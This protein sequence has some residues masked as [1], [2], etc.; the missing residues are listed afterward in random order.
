MYVKFYKDIDSLRTVSLYGLNITLILLSLNFLS[1]N[2]AIIDSVFIRNSTLYILL[3]II[4]LNIPFKKIYNNI[5]RNNLEIISLSTTFLGIGLIIFS[6]ILLIVTKAPLLWLV[7]IPIFISGLDLTLQGIKIIRKE[8]YLIFL[9]SF[10]Y[11]MFYLLVQTIPFLWH[12]IQR[13][14]LVV[15]ST[16][17]L[18]IGKPMLLGPTASGL[19]IIIIFF[20]IS[21]IG[22]FLSF[23]KKLQLIN[24]G[25]HLVGVFIIWIIYLIFLGFIDF[26]SK[27]DIV[28]IHLILFIFCLF[29]TF[30]YLLKSNI[31]ER[32]APKLNLSNIKIK[33]LIVN[34]IIWILLLLFISTI[35][36]TS[37]IGIEESRSVEKT[38]IMFYGQNMLGTW[39]IPEYGKYGREASG[40]FGLLPLYLTSSGFENILLV[41]NIT[42][43]LN[44][45]QP[46]HENI[47]RYINLTDYIT[48]VE[49]TEVTSDLMKDIDIF[50][51]ININKSFSIDEKQVIWE[52]VKKGGSLLVLGEHTD[53]GGVQKPLN[54]LLQP[55]DISF[56]FDSALPLDP[57][58]K[59]ITCYQFMHHPVTSN[60]RSYNEIQ[61]SIGAS[62]TTSPNAFP[63]IIGRYALSDEG[64]LKNAELAYLGDYEYNSGEQLG[65]IILSAAT[66]YGNGKVIVFGDTSTFQNSALPYSYNFIHNIFSWLSSEQSILVKLTQIGISIILLF[67]ALLLYFI[68][69]K[70]SIPIAIFPVIVSLALITSMLVN[71]ILFPEMQISGNVVYLDASH[72]DRFNLESYTDDSINGLIQ[73][74]N[75][76]GYLPLILE[77]FSPKKIKESK[78]LIFNAPT[79]SFNPDEIKYLMQYMSNG[80]IIILATGYPDKEAANTLLEKFNLD[81]INIPL[82]PIPYIG[83]NLEVYENEPRFVDSWP[84]VFNENQGQSYYNFT[85]EIN[86]HLMVFVKQGKG[87]LLLISDSQYLLNKN[88]ESIYDYWPGNIIVLKH[89]IDEFKAMEEQL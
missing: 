61:I 28:S 45:T 9:V 82:G 76:N 84:I 10:S 15:T 66:Y 88:I 21:I 51:L 54:D 70:T 5:K 79:K 74:L 29:I 60:I 89:I 12:L 33:K 43:F 49:S 18:L 87:G 67:A 83:E 35:I 41:D 40:M 30:R 57:K 11:I 73:N 50:V 56:R 37:F 4:I 52:Y 46:V 86:Y 71:P 34:K 19:W 48:F 22:F 78:I 14:S 17:G 63:L 75:R 81:I 2:L 42:S 20:I 8:F 77:E 25:L 65:D 64:D 31:K 1:N 58:F 55:F 16:I 24:F 47:S 36:L 7:S 59:W 68:T 62:L 27:N 53:V 44:F 85:W 13:F 32:V 38:K 69:R 26:G 23:K 80:G 39:D 72:N 3:G 6:F